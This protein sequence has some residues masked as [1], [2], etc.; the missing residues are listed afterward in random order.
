MQLELVRLQKTVGITFIIVTHDQD[1]A[2]SMADRVA[3]METG[4][5]RQIAPPSELYEY[6]ASRF[7]ADFIGKMNL[8]EGQVA[9]SREGVLEV[10]IAGL[11]NLEVPHAG[12]AS[13]EIGIAIRPEKLR[14]TPE[15]PAQPCICFAAV[16]DTVAYHGGESHMFFT[17][18]S[19]AQLTATVQNDTRTKASPKNGER[20]WVSWIPGDTLILAE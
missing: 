17:T 7:V 11:G 2:L 10:K 15:Q 5:V 19:G 16:L 1:E 9:S 20:L 6:P 3:V 12:D 4:K 8:F 14:V 13:G 18:D